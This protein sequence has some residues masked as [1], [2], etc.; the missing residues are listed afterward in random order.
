MTPLSWE[1]RDICHGALWSIMFV[2][3]GGSNCL[4]SAALRHGQELPLKRDLE[5]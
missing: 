1:R 2:H 5:V 3:H 4:L